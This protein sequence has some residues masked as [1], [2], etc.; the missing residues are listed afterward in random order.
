MHLLVT[1]ADRAGLRRQMAS[2]DRHTSFDV[3]ASHLR[4]RLNL[5]SPVNR[6]IVAIPELP[7]IPHHHRI[8]QPH[9]LSPRPMS[10]PDPT[11]NMPAP[12]PFVL[13]SA[14]RKSMLK[15]LRGISDSDLSEQCTSACIPIVLFENEHTCT[16]TC[17]TSR[18]EADPPQL[19]KWLDSCLNSLSTGM[20]DR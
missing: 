15:T 6:S 17:P 3:S 13:K 8:N 10:T 5:K 20:P 7:G 12:N 16:H 1:L 14:L 4:L 9:I 11:S 18:S 19:Q 2:N